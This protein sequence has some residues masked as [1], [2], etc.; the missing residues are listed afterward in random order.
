MYGFVVL[1]SAEGKIIALGDEICAVEGNRIR[2]RT[3]F[4]FRDGSVDDEVTVIKQGTVFELVSDHHVQRGPSFKEPL[5]MSVDV[6]SKTV[7]WGGDKKGQEQRH[8]EHMDL[9]TD[10]ANGMASFA[11]ENFP[12]DA[13]ELTV[14]YLAGSEK[15]RVVKLVVRPDG[16]D[17]FRVGGVSRRARRYKIHVDVGG[18][19]GIIAPLIGKQP[20][21]IEMWVTAGQIATLLKMGGPLYEK[22][23]IWTAELGAPAW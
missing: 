2:L 20:P 12:A 1:K 5:D 6:P 8:V 4:H 19:T 15:P 23:P 14:S 21:D 13:A 7:S 17:T 3:T 18:L 16:N 22:G 9:P 10:L 11:V